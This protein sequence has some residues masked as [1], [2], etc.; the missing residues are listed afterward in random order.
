[1]NDKIARCILE[2]DEHDKLT[3]ELIKKKY[4]NKALKCHPDKNK[5]KDSNEQFLDLKNAYDYLNDK[6][7]VDIKTNS[8]SELLYDFLKERIKMKN[9]STNTSAD[10]LN[11]IIEKLS[12]KCELKMMNLLENID[13]GVLF[14]IYKLIT[15]NDSIFGHIDKSIIERLK[16]IIED[17]SKNDELIIL[18]PTLDDLIEFNVYKYKIHKQKLIIPLWHRELTYDIS[19]SDIRVKCNPVLNDDNFIDE[20]NNIHIK[21]EL[22]LLDIWNKK[23][24]EF[25]I[26]KKVFEFNIDKLTIKSYQIIT[27]TACGI[28]RINCRNIYDITT[29]GDVVI[30]INIEQ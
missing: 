20:Y 14:E 13:K 17:R 10:L 18:N 19:N 24:Y 1:M 15:T 3:E 22:K 2:I 21:L 4:R 28:P 27:L 11:I 16:S 23:L 29:L 6:I 9:A 25:N 26:G 7:G 30:H 12:N 8:Y 5:S